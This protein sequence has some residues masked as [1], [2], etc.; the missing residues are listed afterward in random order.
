MHLQAGHAVAQTV[1]NV[2]TEVTAL[3]LT[4]TLLVYGQLEEYGTQVSGS[5]VAEGTVQFLN[6]STTLVTGSLTGA[7][8]TIN[9]DNVVSGTPLQSGLLS[10]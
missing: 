5:P 8:A 3:S 2:T 4:S 1:T 7:D 6:G 10:G 9:S